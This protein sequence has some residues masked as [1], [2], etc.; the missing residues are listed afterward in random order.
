MTEKLSYFGG[1]RGCPF[2]L[3]KFLSV[4]EAFKQL[5]HFWLLRIDNRLGVLASELPISFVGRNVGS[6]LVP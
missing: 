2:S 5:D 4:L 6:M 1:L 3:L